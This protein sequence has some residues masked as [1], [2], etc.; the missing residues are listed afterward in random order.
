MKH[1][2]II[3][4]ILFITICVENT[5]AQADNCSG[6]TLIS[7]T[8]NC[9]T[10]TNGTTIGATQN[11]PGCVGNADDDVWYQFV[12]TATSHQITVVASASFDPVV[13]LFS[14]T[15]ATLNTIS[16]M[17]ATFTGQN[18]VI[19]ATGLTIGATYRIRVY[20]YGVGSGSG[21]FTICITNPPPAPSNDACGGAVNLLVNT[22]CS[23]TAGTTIGATQSF[24]GC[25]G[26]ADDDVWYSFTAVN[27]TATITVDPSASMDAVLQMY[28]GTCGTLNSMQCADV[29]FTNGNEVISAVGLTVGAVYFIRVY[30]YYSGGGGTFDICITG[31]SAS[32]IP[33]NDE[34]CSAI[35]LPNPTSACNFLQFTTTNATAS[36]GAPTPASCVGGSAPQQG[37][38][39]ASS[40]DVWFSVVIPA[41]GQITITTQP[42]Y[43]INDGAMALYSGACGALAQV[44]CSDDHNYP[45]ATNDFKPYINATG[46]TPGATYF[47][48]YWGYGTSSGNFGLCVSSA[49][50]DF[51]A[52]SLY[53]CDLNG[54]SASTSAAYTPDRP[55]NMYGNNEDTITGVNQPDGV[56]TGG[57]F[58]Q[59]GPWGTGAGAFDVNINNNSWIKFTA[60][61]TTAILNVAI[62]NCWVGSYPSGGIQMQ[63]F[64][65]TGCC[66]FVPVSN[67]EEN[68]TGFTITANS[69]TIGNDY[70]LMVDGFA[71]DICSYTI[72]ANAGVQFPDI[73]TSKP[74]LCY[75]DSTVLV[76]PVGAS[77]YEWSPG[78]ETTPNITVTPSTTT[79]YTLIVSGVCGA[80]QT[81]TQTI[82]VNPLPTVAINSNN[83]VNVCNGS[84][85][86]LTASGA[87]TYVWSTGASG[88]SISVSPTADSTFSV[89]GTDVNG[90]VDSTA[91]L[92]QVLPKPTANITSANGNTICVGESLT[93]SASGGGTYT[94]NDASTLDSL[95]V[96]PA[97]STNYTV[98]ANV[99][100]CLDTAT[101]AVNVNNLPTPLISGDNT[102]C[103]GETTTLTASGGTSY[104]WNNGGVLDSIVVS[105]TADSTYSVVVTDVNNCQNSTNI[106]VTVNSLPTAAIIGSSLI[107]NGSST[108]LTANGGTSYVWNNGATSPSINVSPIAD[109]TYLVTAT[110]VNGC[111]DTVSTLVQVIS[112]PTG[113]ITSSNGTNF[114]CNGST[115]TL[116]VT[117]GGTYTWNDAST[118]DSLVVSPTTNTTYN[119]IVEVG[120]CS[121]TATFAVTVNNLP[122]AIVTGDNTIC[123]G[124]T[125]TLTASGGISY[126]WT[127]GSTLDSIIVSPTADSSYVVTVTDANGCVNTANST[128]TVN[129]LPNPAISGTSLIC[130]G[131]STTLTASGGT[132]YV[133]NNGSTSPSINVSPI[134]DSTYLV[135]AT[136]ANGCSDTVSTLVQ[137][138]SN[139]T[140]NITSSNGTNF[141]C[142]GSTVTLTATGG[143]T[144]TWNDASTLDSLVVSPIVNTTYSVIVEVGGCSDTA[145]FAVTVNSLPTVVVTGDNTICNGESTTLTASGGTSYTWNTGSTLDSIV[146]SPTA[147]SSYVVTVT[148]ANGC[149]N[150]ANSTVTVNALPNPTISGTTA[151][152]DGTF[153]TLTASGGT[154]Y[155]WNNGST[156]PSINVSPI[157]DSTYLV[158]ATDANGCSDTVSTLVQVIS[159]PTANIISSNGTNFVCNGS[160]VTLTASGGGTYT[161]NDA[162]TL[163]SL[164]VS[165]TTNTTYNVIVEVGGCSDTAYFA[166]TVNN[167]PTAFVTGDNIICNGE[168]TTL[169]ASGGVSY[170]WNTGSTLDSIIVSPTADSTYV[171]TV[172]DSNGC[173]NTAN[174]TVTVNALPVVTI[175]GAASVCNGQSTTLN[176]TGANSYVWNTTETTSTINVAPTINPT[177]Y[178]VIG[179]GANGCKDSTQFVVNVIPKPIATITSDTNVCFGN[180]LALTA[181]GGTIYSWDTGDSTSNINVAPIDTIIYTVI[182]I[183]NGCADTASININVIPLPTISAYSDT[184]IIMGQSAVLTVASS[185]PFTW[186][187][188]D[189]ISCTNCSPATVNPKETTTYCV[190]TTKNGCPNTSCVTVVVDNVCGSLFVPNAFTPNGDGSNDC[191]MVYNN[192]LQ[193]VLFRVY[194]RWGVMLF[195]SE[196]IDGCWDG[197]YNGSE[198]NTGVYVFTVKATLINGEEVE[199]KG[200]VSLFR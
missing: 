172:T 20:H 107:C 95:V 5:F 93:L 123:V 103:I 44:A 67:F 64:S 188:N 73:T 17:D 34:P 22:V 97:S 193:E 119:V 187:P 122:T 166:V 15:C 63:I 61:N 115:V 43:G 13:Q 104:L 89:I 194:S 85:V 83:P 8:A 106:N 165:P 54:Y 147:D 196:E 127:T 189:S 35:A 81:L 108:T 158:T 98:V 168:T 174:S 55:C 153:T 80:K 27:S 87:S 140:A 137:V 139:P 69:L 195:E 72:T 78:G 24:V 109:S 45:G 167:L 157:A 31:P 111:S 3:L 152:C 86:N 199:L 148:D 130:N 160:S 126:S 75:G 200:N 120:G 92:V 118:L 68:S 162:S 6:A 105:P 66:D 1:L 26:T 114:V 183:E 99:N 151:I 133:W 177:T 33:S 25:A 18:E 144:Y 100:G 2:S 175:N 181:S 96:S 102:I 39:S 169:T 41:N 192:C 59:A 23:N 70:Y 82:A 11:I 84:S 185:T 40:H 136:D 57:I 42:G 191:V 131:N 14:S 125:T 19:N 173:V 38:F 142:N 163:D 32:P 49:S 76:G 50:N 170:S 47:I 128:V 154:S 143:G 121:D 10:P 164:V 159:N 150:T 135:T 117:G 171:V 161:W 149:V 60:S 30:D 37:G 124:E 91:T 90:C 74:S 52:S 94:W 56:N 145:T 186:S 4:T 71:G 36:M 138:I 155:V 198:M 110:D 197:T 190:T 28:S 65:S 146:V 112:N 113:I 182:V 46:L 48:R 16:C 62:G 12:A 101:F 179:T 58:G 129:D 9:S 79:T 180:T 88:S 53:I 176:A 29:G 156:S 77:S 178:Q 21:T 141:V 116:T 51:C 132:S 7:V 184:T 134:A